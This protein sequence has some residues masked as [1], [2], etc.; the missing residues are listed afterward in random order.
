MTFLKTRTAR[1]LSLA[2]IAA[3][4][5]GAFQSASRANSL[6]LGVLANYAVVDLGNGTTLGQNSG[7][8]AGNELLGNGV[9][10]GFAGGG[11]G[12]LSNGGILYYD[13]TVLGTNTFSQ[14]QNPPTT[15]LVPTTVTAAALSQAQS[16][17]NAAS[18]LGTTQTFTDLKDTTTVTGNGGLN[19]IKV[20]T[21][22]SLKLSGSASDI[23]VFNVSGAFNTNQAMVLGGVLPSHILFNFTGT[24]GAVF[25]TAGGNTV[26]GTFLATDGGRFQFSNLD[27]TGELINTGG[28]VQL[29]SGSSVPTFTPF[30]TPAPLPAPL[31]S[32]AALLAMLG[33]GSRL[34][35]ARAS[36]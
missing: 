17:S 34:R 25:Q 6:D 15:M 14:L 13:S 24:S 21:I 18:A 22:E 33:L 4:F 9:T 28:D 20:G 29:V 23:F 35:I 5:G 19:V 26:Y 31:W 7:P 30:T 1:L 27:L 8:V 3:G 12:G 2:L 11:N 16:V 10:A 36:N 32:A